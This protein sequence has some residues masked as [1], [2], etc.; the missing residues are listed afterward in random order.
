VISWRDCLNST[1]VI[2]WKARAFLEV[3]AI[4]IEDD[5]QQWLEY[6]ESRGY[7]WINY[8]SFDRW[9]CQIARKYNPEGTPTIILLDSEKRVQQEPLRIRAL[10]RFL[11]GR[12]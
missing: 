2:P 4:G 11:S 8:S 1:P 10:E 6:I 7:D 9:D 3:I 5:E 12:L